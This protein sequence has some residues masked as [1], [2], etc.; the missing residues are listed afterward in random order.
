MRC[1]RSRHAHRRARHHSGGQRQRLALARPG[2][3]AALLV[4]DDATSSVDPQVEAI[5]AG[6]ASQA[7]RPLSSSPIAWRRSRS[8]TRS[9]TSSTAACS[10]VASRG[11]AG[12]LR[13]LPPAG[14]GLRAGRGGAASHGR[15]G[16]RM[17]ATMATAASDRPVVNHSPWPR[18]ARQ[19]SGAACWARCPGRATAGRVVVPVTVQQ[20]VDRGPRRQ[21]GPGAHP[22]SCSWRRSSLPA[23]P[24]PHAR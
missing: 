10:T 4:L 3:Q 6:A 11:V 13:G 8:P 1:P 5:L 7:R 23:L 20:T 16:R 17:S 21:A 18:P 12:A 14:D 19:S 24:W 15:G 22:A 9:S 2:T